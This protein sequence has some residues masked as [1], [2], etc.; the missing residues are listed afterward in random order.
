MDSLIALQHV[1][2]VKEAHV[3]GTPKWVVTLSLTTIVNSEALNI[4]NNKIC[5]YYL[6]QACSRKRGG[7]CK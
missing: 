5:S 3:L 7:R 6:Q 1:S 2:E 4:T